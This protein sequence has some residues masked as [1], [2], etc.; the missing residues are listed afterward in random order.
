MLVHYSPSQ[1]IHAYLSQ[2]LFGATVI[3]K[4]YM[5]LGAWIN[6]A[7]QVQFL[8][9]FLVCINT[10][11]IKEFAYMNTSITKLLFQYIS[12][13]LILNPEFWKSC[14]KTI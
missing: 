3:H 12:A 4:S 7:V 9:D 6:S 8:S 10:H 2:D 5:E 13:Y 11:C 1:L 14:L